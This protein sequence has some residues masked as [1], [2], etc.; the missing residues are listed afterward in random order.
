M[1]K[2]EIILEQLR[3][4]TLKSLSDME[5]QMIRDEVAQKGIKGLKGYAKSMIEKGMRESAY[6]IKKASGLKVGDMVSW[7]S[8]GGTAKG[9]I[10]HIM[11]EGVLGIPKS[12]FKIN[13][14]EDDPAVL[15]RIYQNGKETETL[16][17]HKAST[18]K[19]A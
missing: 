6:A 5:Y 16:V 15:I 17:G 8:S 18:L 14:S 2:D 1:K 9:R 4:T 10:E 19:K 3:K 11:R 7:N 12:S 13:A